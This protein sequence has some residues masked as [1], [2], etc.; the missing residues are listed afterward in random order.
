M[1]KAVCKEKKKNERITPVQ[2]FFFF[3]LAKFT[4]DHSQNEPH[5]NT[6][7]SRARRPKCGLPITHCLPVRV[8]ESRCGSARLLS[9]CWMVF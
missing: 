6:V 3:W 1:E 8:L 5:E 2:G 4:G 9:L 7:G